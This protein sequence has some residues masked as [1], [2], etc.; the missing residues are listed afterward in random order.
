MRL[1][2]VRTLFDYDAWATDRILAQAARLTPE[3]FAVAPSAT[4][5]SVR[6]LL[7]H[8]LMARLLWRTRF[9]TDTSNVEAKAEASVTVDALRRWWEEEHRA[10]R[11]HL[12]TLTDDDL[13]RPFRFERRGEAVEM[14]RWQILFQLIN[15]GTQH[16]AEVAALLTDHGH[17]PG[18][19]DFFY[20][21]RSLA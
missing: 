20:F 18:D 13:D 17:S 9:E 3:Q 5:P 15:H 19:L 11:A 21:A 6:Q 7:T 4:M 8:M 16:R 2:E 10:M 1:A 14:I 12:D